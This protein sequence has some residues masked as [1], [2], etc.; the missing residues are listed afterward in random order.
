L[1]GMSEQ[2]FDNVGRGY[3]YL[4][5]LDR[6][7]DSSDVGEMERI[8]TDN[9]R[10]ST[11]QDANLLSSLCQDGQHRPVLDF[12]IPARYVPSSTPGHG[13][14][15]IDKPLSWEQYSKLLAV[16]GEVGILEAGFVGAALRRGATFV[17][18]EGVT[19]PDSTP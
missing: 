17:R 14:L 12:D 16:L 15:Y 5:D 13:H 11:K 3:I 1:I 6:M 8:D 18:P 7:G 4:A 10:P 19:K 2:D 9:R